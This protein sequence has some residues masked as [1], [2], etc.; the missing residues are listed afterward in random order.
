MKNAKRMFAFISA[1]ALAFIYNAPS[2]VAIAEDNV[3]LKDSVGQQTE[4]ELFIS[5]VLS[6]I[7]IFST[8]K[9]SGIVV[10]YL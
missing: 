2:F 7:L 5:K 4:D 9:A 6:S 1:L 3:D 10:S 8:L